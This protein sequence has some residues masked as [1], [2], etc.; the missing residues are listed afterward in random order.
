[1][2]DRSGRSGRRRGSQKPGTACGAASTL[3]AACCALAS[4]LSPTVSAAAST[5]AKAAAGKRRQNGK[6]VKKVITASCPG[7]GPYRPSRGRSGLK[8]ALLEVAFQVRRRLFRGSLE[9]EGRHK[10]PLAIHQID[11]RRVIHGVVAILQGHFL[12]VDA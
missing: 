10:M 5:P 7:F 11:Q 12:G 3:G 8:N 2:R 4:S 9:V 6:A 1:M